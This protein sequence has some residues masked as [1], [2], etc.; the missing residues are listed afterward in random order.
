MIS[1]V[2]FIGRGMEITQIV[3][4]RENKYIWDIC[5]IEDNATVQMSRLEPQQRGT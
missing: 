5:K 4:Q 3:N 1:A 2:L